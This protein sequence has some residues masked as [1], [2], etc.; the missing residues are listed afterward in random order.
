M[1]TAPPPDA[2]AAQRPTGL[3]IAVIGQGVHPIPA[4]G[5]APVETHIANLVAALR[6]RGEDVHL[7]N[8]VFPGFRFR[9]LV[10]ALWA[11]RQLKR[12]KPDVVHCHS[13]INAWVLRRL[14]HRPIVFT[15]HS[16]QWTYNETPRVPA[17]KE[18][19]NHKRGY[20]AADARIVL[21]S[22]VRDAISRS[23]VLR[24]LP[25]DVVPNG[26]DADRFIPGPGPRPRRRLVG[27]GIVA[28]VKRWHLVAQA[29]AA[30][31]WGMEVVGPIAEPA[32]AERLRQANPAVVLR[33][34][35]SDEELLHALQRAT[36]L[37][38][39]SQAE[40]MPLAVLEGMSTGLAVLGGAALHGIVEPGKTGFIVEEG[41]E[42]EQVLA[43]RRLL[44]GTPEGTWDAMGAAARSTVLERFTWDV[45]ADA[46]CQVYVG[47]RQSHPQA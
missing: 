46:A 30:A 20:K 13:P 5:Y 25:C 37:A 38:H 7:V 24:G 12:I 34:E 8:R 22:T 35:T 40:A 23:P 17:P 41:T 16:R 26:V 14:G 27:V 32:Y 15:T 10:H 3:R 36:V 44:H 43:Y 11:H 1:A 9:L 31:G 47:A 33:G 4:P 2:A 28:A 18:L 19:R 6:R 39:P 42:K 21:S 29:A 45:V